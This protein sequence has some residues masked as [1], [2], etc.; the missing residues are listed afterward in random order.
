MATAGAAAGRHV[1]LKV[2]VAASPGRTMA[3]RQQSQFRPV[4]AAT[5]SRTRHRPTA[6]VL[7]MAA[8]VPPRAFVYG[9]PFAESKTGRPLSSGCGCTWAL[10]VQSQ[11]VLPRCRPRRAFGLSATT[12][13]V[14]GVPP[15]I[16][17]DMRWCAR[18]PRRLVKTR[19]ARARGEARQVDGS[20]LE[21]R[22]VR[23]GRVDVNKGR[24][25]GQP[26]PVGSLLWPAHVSVA[27][28][29][30][31]TMSFAVSPGCL[32]L[33]FLCSGSCLLFV[34]R[35]LFHGWRSRV[36]P[37]VSAAS[38]A[39]ARAPLARTRTQAAG[40]SLPLFEVVFWGCCC[41]ARARAS[42]AYGRLHVLLLGHRLGVL[43]CLCLGWFFGAVSAVLV[44]VHPL[45]MGACTCSC[46]GTGC[47]CF[48]AFVRGGFLGL[49]LPC[50]CS[51]IRCVMGG[52]T[53]S[54]SGTGGLCSSEVLRSDYAAGASVL[55]LLY[56]LLP[57]RLQ[58]R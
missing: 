10:P 43:L 34:R 22:T 54:C 20:R 24:R 39:P 44:L 41:R 36:R 40:A 21:M 58:V 16:L 42:A 30:L 26:A 53:C 1:V 52:C 12:A 19:R 2:D 28:L 32:S 25:R 15:R 47:E 6:L 31:L 45:P 8:A 18:P 55:E 56:R 48:S 38:G 37:H 46:S 7:M 13:S 9:M 49:L 17:S 5:L 14:F 57:E 23:G 11:V 51:C 4:A 27:G 33:F 3:G 50:S 35:V 29:V